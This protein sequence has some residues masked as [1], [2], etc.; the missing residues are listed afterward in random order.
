MRTNNIMMNSHL[1]VKGELLRV[2]IKRPWFKPELFEMPGIT[3][4]SH[5]CTLIWYNYVLS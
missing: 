4:V 3:F 1:R 5:A 2:N